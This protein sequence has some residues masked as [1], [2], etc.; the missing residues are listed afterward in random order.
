MIPSKSWPTVLLSLS[1][2]YT[3][4]SARIHGVESTEIH[5]WRVLLELGN[6]WPHGPVRHRQLWVG[7]MGRGA[8]ISRRSQ[9]KLAPRNTGGNESGS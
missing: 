6:G 4:Y 3:F 8:P 5:R 1:Q 7:A 9:T 2:S